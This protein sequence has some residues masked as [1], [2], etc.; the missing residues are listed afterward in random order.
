MKKCA[1][2]VKSLTLFLFLVCSFHFSCAAEVN[3][4][5]YA[6]YP[7]TLSFDFQ[8][9]ELRSL[10]QLIAKSSH[11]N[12]VISDSVKGTV[13]LKLKNVTWQQ[14][15]DIV[16]KARGL[17]SRRSG[18]V[19][20]ISTI[21]EIAGNEVKLFQ[22]Q[23]QISNLAPLESSI[24]CLK[25]T[26]AKSL[27][28][29]VRGEQNSLLT[30]RGQIAID[31]RTNCVI[32]KDTAANLKE[33]VRAIRRIDIPAKQV[34]IEARIV[35]IDVI[36]EEQLGVRFG[37]STTGHLSG[38]LNAAN[39]ITGGTTPSDV[40]VTPGGTI[41][42]L[43]RLNFNVPAS[44]LFDGSSPGSVALALARLGPLLLDLELSALEAESHAKIIAK[45]HV[46]TSNQQKAVILT[47]QEIPYQ[48]S[49]SS[50]ATSV[51]FKNAVLSLTIIPQITPDNKIL[52]NIK[53]T[54][55][56][57]GQSITVGT[58]ATAGSVTIPSINTQEVESSILLNDN[59]TVV[60]GG[61][62][63]TLK[64]N[65]IDRIPFLGSLPIVGALF[66][67][68]GERDEKHELLIFVT[69]KII[70][71][72][73]KLADLKNNPLPMAFNKGEMLDQ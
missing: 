53:A 5:V 43:Q 26:N 22:S 48:E 19:V 33:V 49:T 44:R 37:V 7:P 57:V 2:S 15:L 31:P 10:L 17:T 6:D 34:L 65:V 39:Q 4:T 25:Y 70:K 32:L 54:D 9:I 1:L 35:N 60:I 40:A 12:F 58:S 42:P 73:A 45:P 71:P 72:Q 41:D 64:A 67:H 47:G 68:N 13:S 29:L 69:P 52:L 18:N 62:Y 61:V 24:I 20:Y 30:P 16:L 8:N 3:G 14:A 27:S 50:G 46:V 21:E 38:T 55:D 11:L 23:E 28:E 51:S 36:Y 56:T 66:R 63:R 59:E